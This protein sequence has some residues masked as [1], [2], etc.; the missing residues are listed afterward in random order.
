VINTNLL[1]IFHRFQDIAFDRSKIAVFCYPLV[2]NSPGGG[3]PLGR[4]PKYFLWKS[5]D[6]QGTKCCRNIAEN[7]NRLSSGHERH[8]RQTNDRQTTDRRAIA[9]SERELMFTFAKNLV[10]ILK[11]LVSVQRHSLNTTE[12]L[13]ASSHSSEWRMRYSFTSVFCESI[14][15]HT[16]THKHT[17]KRTDEGKY[18]CQLAT[19]RKSVCTRHFS[20]T[21]MT[22]AVQ[23]MV[24]YVRMHN[25]YV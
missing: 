16:H 15:T 19:P 11:L 12:W 23:C 22:Q 21:V 4:S 25:L 13:A 3:V 10:L 7:F 9:Y 20:Y 1:P 2:F 8:R 6:G 17:D 24:H 5:M 18:W 14:V